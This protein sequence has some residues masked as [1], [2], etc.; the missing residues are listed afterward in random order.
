MLYENM[1][2]STIGEK[3]KKQRFIHHL[4]RNEL[5]KLV[6]CHIDAVEKWE[7]DNVYPKMSN[8]KKLCQLF[9]VS[10][11]YFDKYY[12]T[13]EGNYIEKILTY[14][15]KNK[16]SYKQLGC[17]LGISESALIRLISKKLSLS[18]NL[19]NVLNDRSI[20]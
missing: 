20:L 14:K 18:L 5:A 11:G 10:A 13:L 12:E 17:L 8:L 3:I 2:E 6:G 1:P 15:T 7:K 9:G 16:L 19:F 4:E